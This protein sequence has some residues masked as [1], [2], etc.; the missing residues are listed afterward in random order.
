MEMEM[1]TI[2]SVVMGAILSFAVGLS[3]WAANTDVVIDPNQTSS[4]AA[5]YQLIY[6]SDYG[7]ITAESI[8]NKAWKVKSSNAAFTVNGVLESEGEAGTS[9]RIKANSKTSHKTFD[10][11]I[12]GVKRTLHLKSDN[13]G[14]A[15][16]PSSGNYTVKEGA[17]STIP[18]ADFGGG[19]WK[20]AQSKDEGSLQIAGETSGEAGT[21]VA[22][23]GVSA[24]ETVKQITFETVDT[25]YTAKVLVEPGEAPKPL[26]TIPSSGNYMVYAN[27]NF[28]IPASDFGGKAWSQAQSSDPSALTVVNPSGEAGTGV[29]LHGVTASAMERTVTFETDDA[30]YSAKVIVLGQGAKPKIVIPDVFNVYVGEEVVIPASLFG[31]K[32]WRILSVSTGTTNVSIDPDAGEAG[33]DIRISGVKAKASNKIQFTTSDANYE[34]TVTVVSKSTYKNRYAVTAGQDATIPADWLGG[35]AWKNATSADTAY[36]T[37]GATSG[38]AGTGVP[39]HGVKAGSTK[40]VTFCA[41][42]SRECGHAELDI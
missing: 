38:A 18:S 12:D 16:I 27:G 23:R 10:I 19:S 1:K 32:A 22:V 35:K 36:I 21:G 31:N 20:N 11:T 7:I 25:V 29:V 34:L 3:A 6:V 40:N 41:P 42:R 37:V 33:T 13:K 14:T 15:T 39:I 5:D 17:T 9:I 24:S 30:E 26:V 8:G 2:K 4:A 28:T